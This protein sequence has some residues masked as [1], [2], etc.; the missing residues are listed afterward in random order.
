MGDTAEN[1]VGSETRP[2]PRVKRAGY[3]GQPGSF[4]AR[5]A[6]RCG[7]PLSFT[8]FEKLLRA[9]LQ[10]EIEVAV[11]PAVNRV[12]GPI[13]EPLDALARVL[14]GAAGAPR[15]LALPPATPLQL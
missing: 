14:R 2:E 10:G 12:E 3:Q 13:A 15:P 5:A 7:K 9:V 11:L 8:T 6:S 1:E 4:G